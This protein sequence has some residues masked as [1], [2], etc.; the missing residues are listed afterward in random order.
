M[1]V[2]QARSHLLID[3]D[4]RRKNILVIGA[5]T[6]GSNVAMA[7]ASIGCRRFTIVDYDTV[8]VHNLPSQLF[9]S[10]QVGFSKAIML[11]ENLLDRFGLDEMSCEVVDGKFTPQFEGKGTFDII[12]SAADS[13]TVR[14][15]VSMWAR[16][17]RARVIDTRCGGHEV[18][19]WA[20]DADISSQYDMYQSTLYKDS[21]ASP[22][23]CGGE[24]YPA[25]GLAAA[26]NTL[27]AVST[28]EW[29]YRLA[30][31]QVSA[32]HGS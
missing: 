21:E 28:D 12:I 17:S 31:T 2:I 4:M 16:G 5:G 3:H 11:A 29:F 19:T 10:K 32:I 6:V 26:M 18:Q 30:D 15:M 20:Y 9:T 1:S 14:K 25:A 27:A 8:G 7:L 23:P 13:M 24:M 22:L